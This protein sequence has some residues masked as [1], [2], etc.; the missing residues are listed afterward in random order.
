MYGLNFLQSFIEYF[1]I[2]VLAALS[3]KAIE[4]LNGA[5]LDTALS[6]VTVSV[7]PPRADLCIMSCVFLFFIF[8]ALTVKYLCKISTF[9]HSIFCSYFGVL[10]Q[11]VLNPGLIL[12]PEQGSM[13]DTISS[14]PAA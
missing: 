8:I 9:G 13:V 4:F 10:A 5:W 14:R 7:P 12:T 6:I 11:I 2:N 1:V 3:S